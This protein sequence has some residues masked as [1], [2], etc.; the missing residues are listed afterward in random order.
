MIFVSTVN[1]F[2]E[3]D[4]PQTKVNVIP[5]FSQSYHTYSLFNMN[6]IIKY[7]ESQDLMDTFDGFLGQLFELMGVR[8]SYNDTYYIQSSIALSSKKII[9]GKK[10]LQMTIDPDYTTV[11]KQPDSI[12]SAL[13]FLGGLLTIINITFLIKWLNYCNLD[14]R[15]K[16]IVYNMSSIN[17]GTTDKLNLT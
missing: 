1:K 8:N 17:E 16:R 4:Y 9:N 7:Q 3:N 12:V 15:I 11:M 2:S 6:K 10:V 5:L 13:S 14:R